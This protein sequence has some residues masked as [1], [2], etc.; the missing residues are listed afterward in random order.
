MKTVLFREVADPTNSSWLGRRIRTSVWWNQNP[1]PYHLATPQQAG[2]KAWPDERRQAP[3]SNPAFRQ[4]SVDCFVVIAPRNDEFDQQDCPTGQI[5]RLPKPVDEKAS[6]PISVIPK[7]YLPTDP[8]QFTDS[9]RP[10]PQR[11]VAQRHQRGA[12]CGGRGQCL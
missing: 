12:G 10:V 1:L 4:T 5:S 9:H 11:G 3:R 6:R 8:N 7:F 2:W